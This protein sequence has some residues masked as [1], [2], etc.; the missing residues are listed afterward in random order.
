MLEER[1][2]RGL[3]DMHIA[4]LAFRAMQR[5]MNKDLLN[6]EHGNVRLEPHGPRR[7]FN[8]LRIFVW[9]DMHASGNYQLGLYRVSALF[10]HVRRGWDKGQS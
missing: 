2:G 8:L 10:V 5:N 3:D 7:T 4:G 1:K 9:R 6:D